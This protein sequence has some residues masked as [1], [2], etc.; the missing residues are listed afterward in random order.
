MIRTVP[1]LTPNL[2]K[3]LRLGFVPPAVR[4]NAVPPWHPKA[5]ERSTRVSRGTAAGAAGLWATI[6]PAALA[7]RDPGSHLLR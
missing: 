6:T 2:E 1:S 3:A 7:V 4:N 5:H